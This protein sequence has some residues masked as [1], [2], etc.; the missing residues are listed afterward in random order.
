MRTWT[1][2]RSLRA[3]GARLLTGCIGLLLLAGCAP[4]TGLQTSQPSFGLGPGGSDPRA[5]ATRTIRIAALREPVQGLAPP[6]GTQHG[7]R[8]TIAFIFHSG[9]TIYDAQ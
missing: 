5:A 7:D 9:L 2:L 6:G 4:A 8:T 3:G 1:G